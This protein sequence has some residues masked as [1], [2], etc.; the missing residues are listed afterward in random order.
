MQIRGE[1]SSE[2]GAAAMTLEFNSGITHRGG[3]GAH[4]SSG[5]NG[6]RIIP[7]L[8]SPGISGSPGV[9]KAWISPLFFSSGNTWF[10]ADKLEVHEL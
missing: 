6:F 3:K 5:P 2:A 10:P 7:P 1:H 4:G 9:C 8:D